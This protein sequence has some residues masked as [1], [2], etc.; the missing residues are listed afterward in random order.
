[1]V[2]SHLE[3]IPDTPILHI[4]KEENSKVDDLSKLVQNTADTSS[5]VYFK[6]LGTPST[7]RAKILCISSPDNWMTPYIAYLKDGTLPKYQNKAHYLKHEAARFFLEDN[8]LYRRTFSAPTLKC[9]NPDEADNCLREAHEG[10]CGDHLAAKALAYKVIRKGYYWPTI[11]ADTMA[12]M[13]KCCK[14]QRSAMCRSR[15]QAFRGQYSPRFPLL[16]GG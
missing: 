9:V 7:D 1:M 8:Q 3:T 15:A 11:H 14:F 12:Y 13:K 2:Q 4:N 5:L 10:I 16:F 6:D